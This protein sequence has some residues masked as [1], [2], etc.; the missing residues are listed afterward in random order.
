MSCCCYSRSK[1]SSYDYDIIVIGAGS[2]GL[3]A[4]DFA[5]SIGAR[6]ALVEKSRIGGDCTWTGC[7]PS[8][9]LLRVAKIAHHARTGGGGKTGIT[10]SDVCVDME[11]VRDYVRS[12]IDDVYQHE[13]PE[14]IRKKGVDVFVH[15]SA[16]FTG[17]HT[18]RLTPNEAAPEQ[19][20]GKD[21]SGKEQ[22][23]K[24]S[25]TA[26]FFVVCTG[27]K[28]FVPGIKGLDSVNYL[29]YENIFDL[30]ELP[31][32]LCVVGAGPIGSELAQAFSRL[33]SEVTMVASNIL[34]KEHDDARKVIATV[35][36]QEGIQLVKG[37]AAK[38]ETCAAS[39]ADEDESPGGLCVSTKDGKSVVCDQLLVSAGRHAVTE[40]LG[41]AE[42]GV[43]VGRDGIIVNNSLQTS[44]PHIYAAGDCCGAEQFTHYAGW[45]AFQA[46]RN[47]LL[48]G[49]SNGHSEL[50]PRCTFTDPEIAQVGAS[51]EEAKEKYGS[52]KVVELTRRATLNDRAVCDSDALSGF[53]SLVVN[54]STSHVLGG[55]VVM[56]RAG[57]VINEIALAVKNKITILQ[58]GS[59]I[60]A[61]P[62]YSF[63]LQQLAAEYATNQFNNSNLGKF[64]KS[65]S[66]CCGTFSP[67]K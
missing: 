67:T 37:R 41:L 64:A 17:H 3:T 42:I 60:H 23:R 20:E 18:I 24:E 52:E 29:T 65:W 62:S 54:V 36:E 9:A 5:A 38:V 48:P 58:L 39:S 44:V 51:L 40:N 56:A 63:A 57:E 6:V 8:K 66:V 14:N 61:Y 13:A 2:G 59:T 15:T 46:V 32:R 55:R 22:D 45:Q 35:F 50:V 4:A 47:A 33:G 27:A 12:R 25:V 31:Q 26:A 28:P 34:P 21:S 10:T 19:A 1:A 30:A 11:Q 49:T 53:I 43:E 16:T 7:V